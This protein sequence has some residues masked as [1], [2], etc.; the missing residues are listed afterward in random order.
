MFLC[1]PLFIMVCSLNTIVFYCTVI[2]L[3]I[4]L[5]IVI[6]INMM[7]DKCPQYL[8][9]ILRNWDYLPLFM[10]SLDPYDR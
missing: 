4:L 9:S 5:L 7:Q 3:F 8:P 1:L 10:R 6:L 2:P